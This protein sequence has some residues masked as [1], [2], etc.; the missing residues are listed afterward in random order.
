MAPHGL[1]PNTID[2][3]S[4]LPRDPQAP[5]HTFPVAVTPQMAPEATILIY[6]LT[7]YGQIVSDT[8]HFPVSGLARNNVS[9]RLG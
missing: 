7:S 8:L 9:S 5:L 3:S 2:L 4:S 1:S 6:H